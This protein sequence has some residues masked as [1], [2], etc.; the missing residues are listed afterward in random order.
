MFKFLKKSRLAR[1]Q[2]G[3][4][5]IELLIVVA[6]LGILAAIAIPNLGKFVGSS[7][8]AAA[9]GEAGMVATAIQAGMADAGVATIGGGQTLGPGDVTIS[10]NFTAADYIQGGVG[11]IQGSYAINTDG[12][13]LQS[14]TTYPGLP[15]GTTFNAATGKFE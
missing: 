4:T 3:F 10:G 8:V 11:T 14:G 5:L 7:K 9:N 1:G 2:K 12:R 13:I 15:T 6:I